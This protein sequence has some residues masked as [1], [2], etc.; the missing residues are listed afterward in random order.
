MKM[1][2]HSLR[3]NIA[4]LPQVPF[5]FKGTVRRNIDPFSTKSEAEIQEAIE[6]A[7]IKGAIEHVSNH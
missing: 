3:K 5:L 2:L 6:G 7:G 1:G 4:V